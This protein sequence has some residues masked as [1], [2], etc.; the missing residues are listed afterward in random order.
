MWGLMVSACAL[1]GCPGGAQGEVVVV[2]EEAAVPRVRVEVEQGEVVHS[3]V[4]GLKLPGSARLV[5]ERAVVKFEGTLD[6]DP[7]SWGTEIAAPA[8]QLGPGPADMRAPGSVLKRVNGDTGDVQV[9]LH[10]RDALWALWGGAS[11][12]QGDIDLTLLDP[13]GDQ[14]AVGLAQGVR[15]EIRAD[16]VPEVASVGSAEVYLDELVAAEGSGFLRPEEGDT[17]LRVTRGSVAYEGGEVREL[18]GKEI[19]LVWDGSRSRVRI[20]VDP[21]V[22]GV[23]PGVFTGEVS[24]ENR[25]RTG[26]R[27]ASP[28]T[29][30]VSFSIQQSFISTLA[31]EGQDP[32]QGAS[33][34]QRIEVRGRGLLRERGQVG[35]TL[36]FEGTFTPKDPM[37]APQSFRGP[38]ALER[39]PE[40]FES[41][42]HVTFSIWYSI[43]RSGDGRPY[44]E[45]LGSTVGTFEGKIT[46]R[47][48][49]SEGQEQ[50]GVPW[51]GEFRVLPTKQVVYLKYLPQFSKA[52]EAYGLRNVEDEL[53]GRILRASAEFYRDYNVEFVDQE[54]QGYLDF[55]TIELSGPDPYGRNAFGFDNSFNDVAKD[56]FNLFLRDYIGGWSQGAKEEF[57]NPFGG[58]Y[59]ESFDFFS[60]KISA[61]ENGGVAN[62]AASEKFDEILGPFMPELGGSPVRGT[63]WP[64][65]PRVQEIERALEMVANIIGNTVA[66][67][68][69]HSMGLAFVPADRISPT[70]TFH[71]RT[72]EPGA[73]M[74][75]GGNRPFEERAK[76]GGQSSK[77]NALN[78]GYLQ[79]ILPKP[80]P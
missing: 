55:A 28:Q 23:K 26:E 58:I 61:K 9:D 5:A 34:G 63:E 56:T 37:L 64:E 53:R 73:L 16:L 8:R 14:A 12:F 60:P 77:F 41:E 31:C 48:R 1:S 21:Q 70:T 10:L 79:D 54:P 68:V 24:F 4:L 36:V 51:V 20:P 65:G 78:A 45:G 6:G 80:A 27:F 17:V 32:C 25:L 46:P 30:P 59:I 57:D 11:E 69:G 19:A 76:L 33:R 66:H 38:G 35:M 42:Q 13:F 39:A 49:D 50:E 72:D 71:N 67:E 75:D 22:V 18:A 15:F 52:L 43:Q 40:G 7:F 3:S 2:K 29:T 44:L 74:D 62:A 47:F